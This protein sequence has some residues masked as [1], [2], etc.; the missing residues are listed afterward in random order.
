MKLYRAGDPQIQ[1][2]GVQNGEYHGII[3]VP[4]SYRPTLRASSEVS[5][6][7]MIFDLGGT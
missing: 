1:V 6:K 3:S 4:P 7:I 5:L 2:V